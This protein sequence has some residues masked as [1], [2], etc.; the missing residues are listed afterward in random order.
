[1]VIVV[2]NLFHVFSLSF[3]K[4]HFAILIIYVI[5]NHVRDI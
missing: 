4:K 5:M 1:M 2:K 3:F